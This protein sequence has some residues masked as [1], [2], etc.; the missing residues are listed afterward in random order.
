MSI[1][2]AKLKRD[3]PLRISLMIVFALSL[4]LTIT[5]LIMLRYSRHAMKDDALKKATITLDRANISIDNIL[6]SVEETAGNIYFNMKF[7]DPERIYTYAHKIV[8]TNPY[9]CGCVIAFKPGFFKGHEKFMVYAHCTNTTNQE[10]TNKDIVH[11][12]SFGTLPYTEQTWYNKA[13]GKN[14][15]IWLNP[16]LNMKSDLEPLYSYCAPMLDADGSPIGVI[17][18]HVPIKLLSS[19]IAAAKP[20]PNSYCALVDRDGSFIVDPT[21]GYLSNIKAFNLPGES[22][23]NAVK[24]MMSGQQGY[25]PFEI[26]GRPFHMFYKPFQLAQVP[27]R[28]MN[29]SGWSIGVVFSED[30]I[31]GEYNA[32]FNYVIVIAIVGMI[33]MYLHTRLIIRHRLKPLRMLTELTKR[34]ANGQY[35]EPLPPRHRNKDVIGVLQAHFQQMQRSVSAN[36]NELHE[37]TDTIQEH[38]KE[39]HI[40]YEQAQKADNMKTVF[41][42]N[43]TDQMLAPTFAIDEDVSALSHFDKATSTQTVS[44]LVDNIQQNGDTITN[45]LNNLINLSEKEMVM[46]EKGGES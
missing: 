23:Q 39:L 26:D 25:M 8:E 7:D 15:A 16:L 14:S 10:Q 27:Y 6:L 45:V 37:L 30:D 29:N 38:S 41:L 42:H 11:S 18:V 22:V 46:E 9:V 33:L 12:N 20:S 13:M 19:A 43:M 34:I 44:Q 35:N 32:L 28:D 36:I 3:L 24:T 2:T 1:L 31:F 40:A 4:L 5:L 21:A 17:S